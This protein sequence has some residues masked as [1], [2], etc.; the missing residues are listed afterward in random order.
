[1]LFRRQV[2]MALSSSLLLPKAFAF[3]DS[4]L[5]NVAELMLPTGTLSRPGAW[6]RALFE[7]IQ[8]TSIE[9][10]PQVVQIAPSD[11]NL[12]AHPFSVLIGSDGFEPLPKEAVAMLLRYVSYGGFL[13]FD[14]TTGDPE[15]PFSNSV[16]RLCRRLFPTRSLSPLRGD[17]SVYRSFF[18]LKQPMG[19][20]MV[21]NYMEGVQ[22]GEVTPLIYCPNDLSGALDRGL[23][24]RDKFIVS[25]G[26]WQRTEAVKL[27]INLVMY[28]LTSNYK[29]DQAHVKK[30]IGLFGPFKGF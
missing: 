30:L 26:E 9:T 13:L 19:R 29:H 12:Y 1:M 28:S 22:I 8:S 27:A 5:F 6:K 2:L 25:G 17:H 21:R 20:I 16:R 18:L 24:G 11:P 14:D 3:G 4:S 10:N 7:V 23:D 15:G